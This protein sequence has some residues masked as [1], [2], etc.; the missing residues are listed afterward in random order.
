MLSFDDPQFQKNMSGIASAI[1]ASSGRTVKAMGLKA[2]DTTIEALNKYVDR[3]T[4]FTVRKGAFQAAGPTYEDG[5][6]KVIFS[7]AP[8]QSEYLREIFDGGVRHP[9]DVGTTSRRIWLPTFAP[10]G[11]DKYGGLPYG[12]IKKL[13]SLIGRNKKGKG[14]GRAAHYGFAKLKTHG[15]KATGIWKFPG[16][17]SYTTTVP[18]TRAGKAVM[19]RG[20]QVMKKARHWYDLGEPI[21][22][23]ESRLETHSKKLIDYPALMEKAHA[24]GIEQQPRYLDE[25]LRKRGLACPRAHD[26]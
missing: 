13:S 1:Q 10:N 2:K 6:A 14:A 25:E 22:M 4:P 8:L 21:L 17:K 19:R 3:P 7:I 26:S 24:Y 18:L 20:K 23:A 11:K 12:W 15:S 9:G 5:D 16:R